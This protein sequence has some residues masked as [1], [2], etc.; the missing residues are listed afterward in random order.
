MSHRNPDSYQRV[1]TIRA[2]IMRHAFWTV[3]ALALIYALVMLFAYQYTQF[4]ICMA[5]VL[6][7]SCIDLWVHRRGR[8]RDRSA[9]LLLSAVVGIAVTAVLAQVGVTA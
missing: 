6:V 1:G 5:L 8:Y 4:V 3:A 9:T 2:A 7:A